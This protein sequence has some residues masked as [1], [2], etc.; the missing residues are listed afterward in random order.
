MS[1]IEQRYAIKFC[2]HLQKSPTKTFNLLQEAYPTDHLSKTQ[3]FE[4]HKRFREGRETVENNEG[5][6]RHN[7][8]INAEK[9]IAIENLLNYYPRLTVKKLAY[10]IGISIGSCHTILHELLSMNR[11]C[12]HWVPRRL[13]NQMK[14]DRVLICEEFLHNHFH[15]GEA[16]LKRIITEDEVWLYYYDP[17]NKQQSSLWK[18]A[19]DPTPV[20]PRS[21]KSAGKDL[22]VFFFDSKGIVYRHVVPRETTVTAAAYVEKLGNLRDAVNRKRPNLRDGRWLL[23]HDNAP[24]HT[25]GKVIEFLHRNKMQTVPN[26]PYS[27]NLAPCDFFLFPTLKR[28]LSGRRFY[29]D[30]ELMQAIGDVTRYIEKDGLLHVFY[31]WTDRMRKCIKIRSGYV[32]KKS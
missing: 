20:K 28:P 32:T 17:E 8:S 18:K 21:S 23:D 2:V 7:T 14:A 22:A 9:V 16:Y 12:S 6:G 4:W 26:P 30:N 15:D 29:N 25:A 19:S 5:V 3:A 1:N 27:P 31:K 13:T 10:T 24:C 11:V